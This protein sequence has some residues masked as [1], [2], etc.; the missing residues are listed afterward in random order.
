MWQSNLLRE[1]LPRVNLGSRNYGLS[2]YIR[3]RLTC[4]ITSGEEEAEEIDSGAISDP[5]DFAASLKRTWADA[6]DKC[7]LLQA[8]KR[9]RKTV[10]PLVSSVLKEAL[11]WIDIPELVRQNASKSITRSGSVA[12]VS[13]GQQQIFEL[14]VLLSTTLL[15]ARLA[16]GLKGDSC[17]N[18][19]VQQ[20][21]ITVKSLVMNIDVVDIQMNVR[22]KK[23]EEEIQLKGWFENAMKLSTSDNTSA[24][25]S[26]K[27]F[28]AIIRNVSKNALVAEITRLEQN[29]QFS[30]DVISQ[31]VDRQLGING[32]RDRS[33]KEMMTLFENVPST[34]NKLL[35]IGSPPKMDYL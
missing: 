7:I 18:S 4:S 25:I 35:H 19:D 13:S 28:V 29:D 3:E 30:R 2:W 26:L 14:L 15:R 20:A 21:G 31:L 11:V 32:A 10:D 22:I 12:E 9:L 33:I 17:N 5:E 34:R 16:P 23:L 8:R 1:D 6:K 24:L 27:A